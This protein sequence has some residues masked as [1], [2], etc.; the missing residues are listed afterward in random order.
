MPGVVN[1]RYRLVVD[2]SLALGV[3]GARGRGACEHWGLAPGEVEIVAASMG[4]LAGST[5][6]VEVKQLSRLQPQSYIQKAW[7][8]A[9]WR[10]WLP[11]WV[12]L[13]Q[14]KTT[15]QGPISNLNP[16]GRA[17]VEFCLHGCTLLACCACRR[18]QL[19]S[20]CITVRP[21]RWASL[22]RSC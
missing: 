4:A 12:A 11:P 15:L 13:L 10:S 16:E 3:L 1:P 6:L 9:R 19:T 2:E 18:Q 21:V 14:Y 20:R 5:T 7:R 22:P 17:E 8:Q